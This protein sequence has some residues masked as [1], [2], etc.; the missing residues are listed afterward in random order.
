MKLII[1]FGWLLLSNTI[2]AATTVVPYIT[3]SVVTGTT[4]K[5]SET[6]SG[7]LPSG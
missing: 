2:F 7:S 6:L 1:I 5:F 4:F 3:K